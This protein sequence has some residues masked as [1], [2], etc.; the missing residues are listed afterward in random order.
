MYLEVAQ[1]PIVRQ[2][3]FFPRMDL[4]D[5]TINHKIF[6]NL[7]KEKELRVLMGQI[8]ETSYLS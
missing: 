4:F 3:N 6:N 7:I 5:L 1:P 8:N 2:L